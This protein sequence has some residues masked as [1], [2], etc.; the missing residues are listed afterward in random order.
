MTLNFEPIELSRQKDYLKRYEQSNVPVSD[1]TFVNLWGWAQE[2]D[3]EWAWS[4]NLTWIRQT[5]PELCYWSPMGNW[6]NVDWETTLQPFAQDRSRFIRIPERL[7]I[8]WQKQLPFSVNIEET[9]GQWDYLYDAKEL[10]Q[11]K[12]NRFHKKKNLVNQFKKKYD[13]A[14]LPFDEGMIER[15]LT[16]QADWCTWKDCEANETLAMENR[17][18]E[19]V[20]RQGLNFKQLIGGAL[21]V[22][23]ELVSYTIAELV[24]NRHI[25]IHF[26]KGNPAVKGSYQAINQMFL[27]NNS[28]NYWRVNREQDLDD[29]GLRKAKLSYNPIDF[30]KKNSVT[31]R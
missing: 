23:D 22:G 5:K 29:P 6:E 24:L 16:L 25:V 4:D 30:I 18:I 11:L 20:L 21:F 14:Y 13:Y 31:L 12:G 26:E 17:V 19:K 3:L 27:K 9:R 2:Y 1:Y 28:Q 7:A 10:I 8:I 15:A